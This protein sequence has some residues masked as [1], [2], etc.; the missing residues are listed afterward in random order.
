LDLFEIK[1]KGE[2]MFFEIYQLAKNKICVSSNTTN[3]V[4][5]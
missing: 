1:Q 4:G 2:N 5:Q 3:H